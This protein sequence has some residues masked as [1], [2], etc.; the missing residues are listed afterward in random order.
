MNRLQRYSSAFAFGL[1]ENGFER[2]DKL[3]LWADQTNSAEILVAQVIIKSN[4][5]NRLEPSRLESLLLPSTRKK[6]L[7]LLIRLSRTLVHV[8]SCF[9][10][11]QWSARTRKLKVR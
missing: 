11:P 1:I 7:M 8:A 6:A 10:P 4:K 3:L 9:P 5:S 2:G